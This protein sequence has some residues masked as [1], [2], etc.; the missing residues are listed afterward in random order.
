[1][2]RIASIVAL[3]LLLFAATPILACMMGSTMNREE[4]TPCRTVHGKC[5]EMTKTG[6]SRTEVRAN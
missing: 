3:F 6:C 4:S 1:M 5:G 2:R